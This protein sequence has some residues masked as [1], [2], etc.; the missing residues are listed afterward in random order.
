MSK[1]KYDPEIHN[2]TKFTLKKDVD[3]YSLQR[4]DATGK[5]CLTHSQASDHIK[6]SGKKR[7]EIR[8]Y[9]CPH[10]GHWHTT[11]IRDTSKVVDGGDQK[12]RHKY[13]ER[14]K[15]LLSKE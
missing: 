5:V 15:E 3:L 6:R 12:Y 8:I 7:R 13:W 2:A 14:W 4:C 10:C 9:Q 1:P 11:S